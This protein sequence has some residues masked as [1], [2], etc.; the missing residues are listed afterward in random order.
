[1]WN[2]AAWYIPNA[3]SCVYK[4][5]FCCCFTHT[6]TRAHTHTTVLWPFVQQYPGEQVWNETLTHADVSWSS[7]ILYQVPSST[8]IHSFLPVQF[9]CLTIF[10]HNL[11]PS[12]LWST[13]LSG[14]LHFTCIHIQYIHPPL[15]T[16]THNTQLFYCSSGICPG[17][18]GWAGTRNV[19][20]RKVKPIW[21]YWSKR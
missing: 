9:T 8:V 4:Q 6:R 19:K 16:H 21:I 17:L 13:S 3:D 20:T 18:P 15:Y 12:P 5:C 7:T 14:T 1:V 2:N 10:L 11:S